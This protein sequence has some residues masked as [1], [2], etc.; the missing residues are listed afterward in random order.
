MSEDVSCDGFAHAAS[1]FFEGGT[2]CV[3]SSIEGFGHDAYFFP[4]AEVAYAHFSEV[5]IDVVDKGFEELLHEGSAVFDGVQAVE[6]EE[7]VE[8]NH[9]KMSVWCVED[10]ALVV[11]EG[12]S[13]L[14]DDL[15]VEILRGC[16]DP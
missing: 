5:G 9:I 16:V 12:D 11:E 4:Y 1:V 13:G 7:E 6:D 10:A 14:G 2:V 15:E 3:E 8:G